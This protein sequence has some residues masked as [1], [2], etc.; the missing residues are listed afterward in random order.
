MSTL[1]DRI[2]FITGASSGIGRECA[3]EL[4]RTGAR[5]LLCA[6]RK[7]RLD[8]LAQELHEEHGTDV[9]TFVLDVRD[10]HAV[11][12]AISA[13][14]EAWRSIEILVNNAGLSRGLASI[15]DGEIE[16]WEEMI[17]TNV[18][19]LLY[20]T[21]AVT[22]GMVARDRGHIVNVGSIAGREVYRGGGVYCATKWSVR[23][24]T[25]ALRMDLH[26]TAIRVTTVDP[27]LVETEFSTV[28]FHGDEARAAAVYRGTRP[29]TPKDVAEVVA[30][31][32]TRPAHVTLAEVVVLATDQATAT[33]VN[34]RT[35]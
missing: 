33:L 22:P 8:Q 35:D 34:R 3:R 4:A 24:L 26:G 16:D 17:D 19:G 31:C 6:R 7:D 9:H 21:R 11:D 32:A 10:R 5:L 14:P 29:L 27:G 13:L 15:P 20:V 30:F 12:Q 25:Q 18:K 28:R 1:R 23:A 2:A